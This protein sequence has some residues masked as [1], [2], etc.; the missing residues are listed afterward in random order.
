MTEFDPSH[1]IFVSY[2][3]KS[4]EYYLASGYGNPYRWAHYENAPFAPLAK[5]LPQ[6]RVALVSTAALTH[7]GSLDTSRRTVF[8]PS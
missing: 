7:E 6:S 4:R 3:D 1:R 2:M 5:P 8:R